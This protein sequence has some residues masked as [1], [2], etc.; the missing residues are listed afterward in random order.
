M[1]KKMALCAVMI[2][3]LIPAFTMAAGPQGQGS[4][5]ARGNCT[6]SQQQIA[7]QVQTSNLLQNNGEDQMLRNCNGDQE[8]EISRIMARNQ[9][10]LHESTA[11]G[12]GSVSEASVQQKY[13]SS[14]GTGDQTWNRMRDRIH[15]QDGSCGNCPV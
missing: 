11:T 13:Q 14:D 8:C 9:S 1:I 10:R 12:Q 2:L 15:L 3:I 7:N 5:T 6:Q 4:D